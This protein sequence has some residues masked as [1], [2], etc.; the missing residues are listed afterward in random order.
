[1]RGTLT[2][3]IFF[4]IILIVSTLSACTSRSTS[5]SKLED[6]CDTVVNKNGNISKDT[7]LYKAYIEDYQSEINGSIPVD[8]Y[9]SDP[10]VVSY[11]RHSDTMI[12]NEN[13]VIFLWPDSLEIIELQDKYPVRYLDILDD[14]ISHASDAAIAMDADGIKNFFCDKSVIKF[15]N[16]PKNIILQRKKV[17]GDMLM[18]KYGEKPLVL[19][20]LEFDIKQAKTFFL[21]KVDTLPNL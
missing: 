3:K 8:E 7:N 15:I 19:Y 5:N 18:F 20:A 16:S 11:S 12:I 1:M 21:D 13:C 4:I 14:M 2:I 9:Y 10:L 17:E 6:E